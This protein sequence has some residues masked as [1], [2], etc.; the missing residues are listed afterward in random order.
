MKSLKAIAHNIRVDA[1]TVWMCAR[2]PQVPLPAR[3]FGLA[4]AA[5]ALSPIDLIPDFIPVLGLLDD[6]VLIPLGI[7]LFMRMIPA[8]IYALHRVA[9]ETASQRP[10][11]KAAASF[12]ILIWLGLAL[13]IGT[14]LWG[15]QFY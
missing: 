14:L 10:I 3:V 1:H 8:E 12:I 9:A 7:W 15:V 4:I 5:Y 2:D 13:W 11:S 6:A